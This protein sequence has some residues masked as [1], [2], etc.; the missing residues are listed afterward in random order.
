M[1]IPLGDV[2]RRPLHKPIVTIGIIVANAIVFAFELTGGDAFVNQWSLVPANIVAGHDWITILT[3]MFMHAGWLHIGGNM[4]F[5]WA[6]GPQIEDAMGPGRYLGFY[7]LG[8]LAAT[9]A[10]VA[11][12]PTST[13]PNLGASGAIA[14]VMGAFI[15]TYPKDRIRTLIY[16]G[17]FVRIPRW[18]ISPHGSTAFAPRSPPGTHPL[19]RILRGRPGART[20]PP[21]PH[22]AV[23]VSY[24]PNWPG[25]SANTCAAAS[26]SSLPARETRHGTRSQEATARCTPG[27]TPPSR[28]PLAY[29]QATRR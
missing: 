9:A 26:S 28:R 4:L 1:G 23:T 6:F 13:I 16:F 7:L 20:G 14:S 11:M 15:V 24:A 8:G 12:V 21:L 29:P 25:R 17:F 5:L 18:T 2:T 22:A 3:A 19:A 27:S 10:Q